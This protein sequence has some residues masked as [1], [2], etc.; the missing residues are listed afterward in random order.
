M[1]I[2][3]LLTGLF[4]AGLGG[5]IRSGRASWL[6]AGYNTTSKEEKEMYDERALSKAVGNLLFILG[7]IYILISI[8]GFL[9]L[10]N[11]R[12]IMTLGMVLFFVITIAAVIYMNTGNRFKKK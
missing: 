5:V 2:T 6:I 1:H 8:A 10:P 12:L 4:L 3:M 11:F 9:N 7:G